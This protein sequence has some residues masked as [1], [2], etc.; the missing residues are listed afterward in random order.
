MFKPTLN[1][2][3]CD[4]AHLKVVEL[5]RL[6]F[7]SVEIISHKSARCDEDDE[8]QCTNDHSCLMSRVEGW[9]GK[10]RSFQ[11]ALQDM[12]DSIGCKDVIVDDVLIVD[13]SRGG[14]K[15]RVKYPIKIQS[16]I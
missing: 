10:R 12:D 3:V 13:V 7:M 4:K 14:L 16:S 2:S 15:Q 9:R 5:K 1:T 11:R 6:C 8:D